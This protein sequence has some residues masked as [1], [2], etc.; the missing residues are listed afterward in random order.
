MSTITSTAQKL[1]GIFAALAFILVGAPTIAA[2]WETMW[3]YLGMLF[4]SIF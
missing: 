4:F 1:F 3:G 2:L